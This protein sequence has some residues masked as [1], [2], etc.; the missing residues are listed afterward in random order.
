MKTKLLSR[1]SY[2][3]LLQDQPYWR[4]N[5]AKAEPWM[6]NIPVR[7]SSI[8]SDRHV[9]PSVSLS[10]IFLFLVLLLMES[11]KPS[12]RE[13]EWNL[14]S[15]SSLFLDVLLL[16]VDLY[17]WSPPCTI[18]LHHHPQTWRWS[19]IES[20]S[21]CLNLSAGCRAVANFKTEGQI[22]GIEVEADNFFFLGEQWCIERGI[23]TLSV[24]MLPTSTSDIQ[25]LYCFKN[26]AD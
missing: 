3:K 19:E 4:G 5:K 21:N 25:A 7:W 6:R 13:V 22:W 17:H 9:A 14:M 11:K 20:T 24:Y 10:I 18:V 2:L 12:G 23:A 26:L 8:P 1:N 15:R 16:P